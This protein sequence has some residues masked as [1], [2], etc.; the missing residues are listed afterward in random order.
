LEAAWKIVEIEPK[1]KQPNQVSFYKSVKS[2][3][4][5]AEIEK[6]KEIGPFEL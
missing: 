1:T 2:S 3:V 4:E 6:I 5:A